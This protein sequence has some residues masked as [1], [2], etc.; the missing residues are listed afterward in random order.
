MGGGFKRAYQSLKLK[1]P[2][3]KITIVCGQA[4][5]AD[6]VWNKSRSFRSWL[7]KTIKTAPNI[8]GA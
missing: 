7:K 6:G 1:E 4:G 8:V 5:R 2:K 3:L